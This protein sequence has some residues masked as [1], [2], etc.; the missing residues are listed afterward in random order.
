MYQLVAVLNTGVVIDVKKDTTAQI[1]KAIDRTHEDYDKDIRY[2][3]VFDPEYKI[4]HEFTPIAREQLEAL[5]EEIDNDEPFIDIRE[6][7]EMDSS[8]G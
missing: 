6:T 3:A 4:I 5:L 7:L 8:N 2:L 1:V